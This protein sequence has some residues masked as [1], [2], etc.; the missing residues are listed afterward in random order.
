LFNTYT[1]DGNKEVLQIINQ[2][3]ESRKIPALASTHRMIDKSYHTKGESKK[4]INYYLRLCSSYLFKLLLKLSILLLLLY[5][6]RH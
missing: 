1:I 6:L 2:K 5:V 3:P 4:G